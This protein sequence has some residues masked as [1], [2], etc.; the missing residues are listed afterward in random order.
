MGK[1]DWKNILARRH[2]SIEGY[3]LQKEI[4]KGGMSRVYRARRK[5]DNEIVAVKVITPEHSQFADM[6][7][8]IFKKGS[9]GEVAASLRH[10]NIVCTHDYG[11]SGDQYYIV[12]EFIDGPNLKQLIDSGDPHW[13][14]HRFEVL[15]AVGRGL[16]HIH[17]NNLIHRD[18]CPKNILLDSMAVPKIIDFGLAIPA[19][20]RG[21]WQFDRSGTASYMAPEQV[22]GQQVDV[23]TDVYAFGVSAYEILSGSRPFPEGKTRLGK[24]EP[25]LNAAPMPLRHFDPT[26]P[27]PL[28]HIL[29]RAM[30]KFPADRYRAMDVLMKDLQIVAS[31]FFPRPHKGN[32]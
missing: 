16:H 11:R 3:E 2:G 20:L 24:M 17:A 29:A 18:F 6:L 8:Q 7:E 9:E 25:H 19:T 31:A 32:G 26:L 23:R 14:E 28:D 13:R 4:A 22:R 21:K 10:R 30:A 1:R 5:V 27:M 12:M 15:L